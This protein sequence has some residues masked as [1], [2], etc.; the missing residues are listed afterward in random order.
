MSGASIYMTIDLAAFRDSLTAEL[1]KLAKKAAKPVVLD[2]NGKPMQ[3][4][5]QD[6]P[7]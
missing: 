5:A 4:V 3:A 1:D 2:A 7:S 6:I